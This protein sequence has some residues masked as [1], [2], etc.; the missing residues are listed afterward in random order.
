MSEQDA[1][2]RKIT[3]SAHEAVT[4]RNLKPMLALAS[5]FAEK[6]LEGESR[7]AREMYDRAIFEWEAAVVQRGARKL[8]A[9]VEAA[10]DDELRDDFKLMLLVMQMRY[11]LGAESEKHRF[12]P[13]RAARSRWE[14]QRNAAVFAPQIKTAKL[15]MLG[16]STRDEILDVAL[17]KRRNRTRERQEMARVLRNANALPYAR[18]RKPKRS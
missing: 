18:R 13:L 14:A 6:L 2:I 4:K 17:G 7:Y 16:G 5:T 11:E 12:R 10:G 15:M 1:L 9:I 3:A 8:A